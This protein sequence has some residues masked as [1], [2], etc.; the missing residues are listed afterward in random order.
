[1]KKRFFVPFLLTLF[2]A[3]IVLPASSSAQEN[4]VDPSSIPLEANDAQGFVPPGWKIE[5]QV[6]GDLNGDA[7]PDYALKRVEDNPATEN[8]DPT[9]RQRG[10]VVALGSRDGKLARVGVADS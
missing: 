10:L 8:G 7:V 9:E 5:E 4:K 2:L 6:K 1:M 3:A